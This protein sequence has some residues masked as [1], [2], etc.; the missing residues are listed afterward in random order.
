MIINCDPTVEVIKV[1]R[2]KLNKGAGIPDDPVRN[3]IQ[4]WDFDGNMLWDDDPCAVNQHAIGVS[5]TVPTGTPGRD[6]LVKRIL[7]IGAR[8]AKQ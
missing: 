5:G 7:S 3:T 8:E 6:A 1:I 4:Y 2:V